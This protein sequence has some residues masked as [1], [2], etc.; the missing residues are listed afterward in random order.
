MLLCFINVSIKEREGRD[1]NSADVQFRWCTIPLIILE[2]RSS[3]FFAI[4]FVRELGFTLAG[5][6][7][8]FLRFSEISRLIHVYR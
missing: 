2:R 5:S 3:T 8:S 4:D 7:F 6:K 1:V